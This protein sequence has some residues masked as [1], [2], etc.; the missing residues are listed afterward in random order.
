M[1]IKHWSFIEI[2]DV[3]VEH[4]NNQNPLKSNCN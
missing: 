3:A 1:I 2:N 4:K